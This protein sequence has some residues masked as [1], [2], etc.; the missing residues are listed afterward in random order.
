MSASND[1]KNKKNK[2]RSFLQKLTRVTHAI[3]VTLKTV[4]VLDDAIR[5]G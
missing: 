3:W 5:E 1:K 4:A 2:S